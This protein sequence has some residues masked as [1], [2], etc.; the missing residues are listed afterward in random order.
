MVT[1]MAMSAPHLHAH[2][3]L[4]EV[5]HL[6]ASHVHQLALILAVDDGWKKVMAAATTDEPRSESEGKRFSAA[7]IE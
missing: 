7:D 4:L 2:P 6:P 3:L 5:R 1:A